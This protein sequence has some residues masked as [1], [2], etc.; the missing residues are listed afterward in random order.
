MVEVIGRPCRCPAVSFPQPSLLPGFLCYL[1]R[2]VGFSSPCCYYVRGLLHRS[3]RL[4]PGGS[5][6]AVV[7]PSRVEPP[8]QLATSRVDDAPW[9]FLV[10]LAVLQ[11]G[12]VQSELKVGQ[13]LVKVQ[14]QWWYPCLRFEVANRSR[15]ESSRYYPQVLVLGPSKSPGDPSPYWLASLGSRDME[16]RCAVCQR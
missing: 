8:V 16:R 11:S 15:L 14:V 3:W 13:S 6:S 10:S 2:V 7:S 9:G 5:R 4:W 12:F 1:A